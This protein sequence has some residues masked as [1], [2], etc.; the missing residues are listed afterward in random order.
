VIL[1]WIVDA[2]FF[3]FENQY[4]YIYIYIGGFGSQ[5]ARK[6]TPKRILILLSNP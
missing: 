5:K 1:V 6:I 2:E 4:I 3:T